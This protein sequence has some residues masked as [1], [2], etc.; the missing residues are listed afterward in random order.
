M[1]PE[2]KSQKKKREG[3]LRGECGHTVH[4]SYIMSYLTALP[5]PTAPVWCMVHI[6]KDNPVSL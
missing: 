2:N 1:E 5:S 4:M 6:I 3:N